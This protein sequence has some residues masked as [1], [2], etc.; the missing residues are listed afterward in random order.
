MAF[1]NYDEESFMRT[2]LI[3]IIIGCLGFVL[4]TGIVVLLW[5]QLWLI[6]KGLT[7]HECLKNVYEG[8][9]NPFNEGCFRNYFN[10]WR[11][12]TT[13]QAATVEYY[14]NYQKMNPTDD[15]TVISDGSS[16]KEKQE[17]N[18]EITTFKTNQ[19]PES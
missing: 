5:F 2:Y 1:Q 16:G 8:I 18:I 17:I 10:F 7:T 14:K 3:E 13:Y 11:K 9:D 15:S 12:N 6:G 19:E 4:S